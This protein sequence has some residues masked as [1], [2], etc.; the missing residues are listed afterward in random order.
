[1]HIELQILGMIN[2]QIRQPIEPVQSN[3]GVTLIF[4]HS[5]HKIEV[6]LY[7]FTSSFCRQISWRLS[8]LSWTAS[9]CIFC[10]CN[11]QRTE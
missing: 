6:A 11:K 8:S 5:N 4:L 10:T 3:C 2:F 9:P 7:E 1:M